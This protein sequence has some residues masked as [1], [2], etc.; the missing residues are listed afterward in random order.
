MNMHGGK[1]FPASHISIEKKTGPAPSNLLVEST[2][3]LGSV[4]S[5]ANPRAT[6][7][8]LSIDT[9]HRLKQ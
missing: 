2:D 8:R 3:T 4:S 1:T 7:R 6:A 9:R 5:A